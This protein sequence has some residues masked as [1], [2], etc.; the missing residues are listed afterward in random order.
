MMVTIHR[1]DGTSNE[2]S[3]IVS[4]VKPKT[5]G[6][7]GVHKMYLDLKTYRYYELNGDVKLYASKNYE[8]PVQLKAFEAIQEDDDGLPF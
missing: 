3:F 5:V 4:K 8:A 6:K 2:V 7:L 1:T